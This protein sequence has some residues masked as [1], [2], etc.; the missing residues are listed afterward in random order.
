[1]ITPFEKNFSAGKHYED[2]KKIIVK[3]LKSTHKPV[4]RRQLSNKTH[5]EISSLC[6]PLFDLVYK[7]GSVIITHYGPCSTTKKMVM[8]F[9][10]KKKTEALPDDGNEQ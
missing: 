7:L 1:M 10:L 4:T 5:L 6:Q 8:H 9:A 3:V 2:K